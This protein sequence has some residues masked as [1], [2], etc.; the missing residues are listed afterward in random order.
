MNKWEKFLGSHEVSSDVR[1]NIE[2]MKNMSCFME[3]ISIDCFMEN[4]IIVHSKFHDYSADG[5]VARDSC[6]TV[7]YGKQ[8][9]T[10]IW[11]YS[12][13]WSYANDRWD[14]MILKTGEIKA[15]ACHVVDKMEVKIECIAPDGFPPRFVT[16]TFNLE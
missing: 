15:I 8:V 9:E 7:F 6:L 5:G 4:L 11:R 12:D 10:K 2:G 16:F 1:K 14:L 3:I 13:K